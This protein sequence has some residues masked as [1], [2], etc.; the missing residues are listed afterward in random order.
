V[1]KWVRGYSFRDKYLCS[2][3]AKPILRLDD[4]SVVVGVAGTRSCG[5]LHN[6]PEGIS[7]GIVCT[8]YLT[9]NTHITATC[10]MDFRQ[11]SGSAEE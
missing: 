1:T 6:I 7:V 8:G 2:A 11:A 9:E 3:D 5:T 10:L 4:G